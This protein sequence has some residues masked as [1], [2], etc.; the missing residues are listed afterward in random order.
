MIAVVCFGGLGALLGVLL[1]LAEK[2]ID[3]ARN[4]R[5]AKK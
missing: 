4:E 5:N 1:V 2:V 3:K